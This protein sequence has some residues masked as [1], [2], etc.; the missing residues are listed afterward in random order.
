[1]STNAV[2]LGPAPDV[3]TWT[4]PARVDHAG[5]LRR[6]VTAYEPVGGGTELRMRFRTAGRS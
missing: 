3:T 5:A 2:P 1:M 6:R 4:M